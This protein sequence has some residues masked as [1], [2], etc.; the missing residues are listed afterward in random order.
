MV[1]AADGGGTAR[2]FGADPLPARTTLHRQIRTSVPLANRFF[3][4]GLSAHYAYR[5]AESARMFR[6]AQRLDPRCVMCFVGE[7]IALGPTIDARM[8]PESDAESRHAIRQAL[9]LVPYGDDGFGESAW[10]RAV[11]VRYIG[12]VG[13][14]RAELDSAY[15]GALR[16]LSD[17]NPGDADAA[18]LAA[19]AMM[20]LSP[21]SYWS[22]AGTPRRGTRTIVARLD[23]ALRVAPGHVGACNL[24]V[25]V[26]EPVQSSPQCG[27]GKRGID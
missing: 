3:D 6:E 2:Y 18:T 9:Q 7:A 8:S 25:H 1:V 17:E 23:R 19:E 13:A 24:F 14:T 12:R 27:G 15:A 26:M 11:A 20:I 10:V 4:A 22:D 21:Y 16:R 5:H